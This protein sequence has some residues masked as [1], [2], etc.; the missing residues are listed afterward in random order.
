MEGKIVFQ[1]NIQTHQ[2]IIIRYPT[3]EDLN[4]M[5]KYINTLSQERTFIRFQGEQVSKEEEE[6]YLN[7][8]L[9]KITKKQAVQLLVIC[10]G[11]IIGISDVEMKDKTEKH[12]GIFG[13][14]IA[15]D[16][17]GKGIGSKLMGMVIN[18][19]ET[20]LSVLEIMIL[21][22]FANNDL[23]KEM[24]KKFGFVEYG[25]LPNG[26]KLENGHV[27]RVLMYKVVKE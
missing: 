17:R 16:F 18:E 1:R 20:N 24:Y 25:V 27:D 7:S 22:V 8:L 12:L 13:I 3:K 14:T 19:A 2:E 4:S 10:E 23:A 26:I 21:D 5:W 6:K 11:E 15:K 9:E